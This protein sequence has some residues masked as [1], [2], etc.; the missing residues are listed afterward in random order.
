MATA[1]TEKTAEAL[2]L[3]ANQNLVLS[4]A[5]NVLQYPY[6]EEVFCWDAQITRCPKSLSRD[7]LVAKSVTVRQV[8]IVLRKAE[9]ER[10]GESPKDVCVY[11]V[12]GSIVLSEN[13]REKF[14]IYCWVFEDKYNPRAILAL[15]KKIWDQAFSFHYSCAG[16]EIKRG[17]NII[18]V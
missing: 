10:L 11:T 14:S 12:S 17:M 8:A 5:R 2:R 16:R 4:M 15:N 6:F 7:S 3:S 1:K 18:Y 9:L 13:R